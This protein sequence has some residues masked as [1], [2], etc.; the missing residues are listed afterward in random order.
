MLI[1]ALIITICAFTVILAALLVFI[2]GQFTKLRAEVLNECLQALAHVS[3]RL[4][5]AEQTTAQAL[6]QMARGN[7]FN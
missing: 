1:G 4:A 5:E 7:P 2:S 6:A 3:E